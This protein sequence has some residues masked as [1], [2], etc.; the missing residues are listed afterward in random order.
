FIDNPSQIETAK[1]SMDNPTANKNNSI[2]VI[3]TNPFS[4]LIKLYNMI[5]QSE[6]FKRDLSA[7]KILQTSLII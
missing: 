3:D 7:I 2:K 5:E 6:Q 1:A 4:Y